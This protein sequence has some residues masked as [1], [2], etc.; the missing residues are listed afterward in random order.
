MNLKDAL[1]AVGPA[2][3]DGKI[4]PVLAFVKVNQ[5]RLY[6]GDGNHFAEAPINSA[7]SFCVRYDALT[8]ALSREGASITGPRN[9]RLSVRA[10]RSNV[11][12][13]CISADDMPSM[14]PAEGTVRQLPD[15]FHE[16]MKVMT[17]FVG[18]ADGQIWTQGVHLM[19]ERLFVGNGYR[20]IHAPWP[21]TLDAPIPLPRWAAEFIAAQSEAPNVMTASETTV[22]FLWTNEMM[23]HTTL[24]SQ[25]APNGVH[26]L[27][28]QM[29]AQI[30]DEVPD[31]LAEALK[32]VHEHGGTVAKVGGNAVKYDADHFNV[33]E[34]I[35]YAGRAKNWNV[36]NLLLALEYATHIKLAGDHAI[37]RGDKYS[38]MISGMR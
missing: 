14:A 20:A 3:G 15:D 5:G 36:G 33:E 38:G 1:L 8:K 6:V 2:V 28:S 10:G 13:K 11:S 23:L 16:M 17:R 7:A 31:G 35:D 25:D 24:L 4:I 18:E 19:D 34:E 27:I 29:T 21:V 30:P 22:S 37:W 12:L 32:H 26:Q 9:D